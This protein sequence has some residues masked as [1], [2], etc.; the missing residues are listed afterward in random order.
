MVSLPLLCVCWPVHGYAATKSQT[1]YTR[2]VAS[3]AGARVTVV[4]GRLS[5][6]LRDADIQTVLAQIAKQ[7]G[8]TLLTGPLERQTVSVQFTDVPLEQGVRR[9]LRLVSLNH[10][11]LSAPDTAGRV[12]LKELRVFATGDTRSPFVVAA[13]PTEVVAVQAQPPEETPATPQEEPPA[14]LNPFQQLA[15]HLQ[16]Q[17][18]AQPQGA[19]PATPQEE[20]QALLNPFQDLALHL[21]EQQQAQPQGEAKGEPPAPMISFIEGLR[22]AQEEQQAGRPLSE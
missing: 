3:E 15:L 16:E 9:L 19:T 4:Q 1:Q 8:F 20:S 5:V 13:R 14:L 10:V 6:D 11:M 2:Q 17:Q 12:A 7:A 22:R 18:K 21:Q